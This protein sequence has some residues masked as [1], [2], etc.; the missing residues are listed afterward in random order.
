[1]S[2]ETS[3]ENVL[4]GAMA[5]NAEQKLSGESS[6]RIYKREPSK[7]YVLFY[8]KNAMVKKFIV[9]VLIQI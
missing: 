2:V 6:S 5:M 3:S 1:M 4:P 7:R 8:K 9:V